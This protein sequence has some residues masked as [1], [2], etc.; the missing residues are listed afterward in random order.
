MTQ[1]FLEIS[2]LD[3]HHQDVVTVDLFVLFPYMLCTKW[4]TTPQIIMKIMQIKSQTQ[5]KASKQ[6]FLLQMYP[7][8][9]KILENRN[10]MKPQIN[11]INP[12]VKVK[13]H[14]DLSVS[15]TRMLITSC[16]Y[17]TKLLFTVSKDGNFKFFSRKITH[18]STTLTATKL[19]QHLAQSLLRISFS[20]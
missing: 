16:S 8:N 12:P 6:I 7:N 1:L 9:R 15:W 18:C 4:L 2:P 11:L 14:Q 13:K 20:Y 17:Q 5:T 10:L 19:Y 3:F